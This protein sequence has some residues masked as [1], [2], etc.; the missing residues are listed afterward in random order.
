MSTESW[1][2]QIRSSNHSNL[3]NTHKKANGRGMG[4]RTRIMVHPKGIPTRRD[5]EHAQRTW[6]GVLQPAQA[7]HDC[8]SQHDPHPN[9]Q[10]SQHTMVSAWCTRKEQL[11]AEFY[12]DW[13]SSIMHITAFGLKLDKEQKRLELLGILIS[14]KDKLQFYMEQIYALATWCWTLYSHS[15]QSILNVGDSSEQCLQWISYVDEYSPTLHYVEG[16]C[17]IIADTF[18]HLSRQDDMSAIVGKKAITEDGELVYYSSADDR[19]IFV[20]LLNLLCLSLNK[21]QKQQKSRKR[22]ESNRSDSHQRHLNWIETNPN[23]HH[24]C[25]V[26]ATH[27]YLN[28][29]TDMEEDNPLDIENIIEKQ[30]EDN[31]LQQ[32]ATTHPEWYSRKTF[33]QVMDV[34]CYTKPGDNPSN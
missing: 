8:I 26:N 33:D 21:K 14:N 15:S 9:P 28:L 24:S 27:W 19:E 3:C 6:W 13:D 4:R 10:A 29:P 1:T 5:D 7:R 20:C 34:L 30:D 18:L 22:C 32:T 2:S 12:A 11:K 23:C 25:D 31:D 17:N 16:P